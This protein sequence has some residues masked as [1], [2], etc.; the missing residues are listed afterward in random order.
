MQKLAE[1]CARRPVFATM[2]A[3]AM[4]VI[5]LISYTHL[6]VDLYPR[7]DI[8]SVVVTTLNPGAGPTEIESQITSQIEAAV[9]TVNGVTQISSTSMEG[10]STVAILFDL[11]KNG[12]VAAQE[13]RDRVDNITGLPSTAMTPRV[14]KLDPDAL[15]IMR[16]VVSSPRPLAETSRIAEAMVQKRLEKVP[17]V[18][19]VLL[20]G[21]LDREIQVAVDPERLRALGITVPELAAGIRQQSVNLPGGRINEGTRELTVRTVGLLQRVADLPSL[22]VS[23]RGHRP[24]LLSELADV[25]DGS[26]ENSGISRWNGAPA[27]SLLIIKQSGQ[28]TIQVTHGIETDLTD[29][30]KALPPDFR[31]EVVSDQSVFIH[32]AI[33]SIKEHLIFG[34]LF[35]C[36]VVFL[37]LRNFHATLIAAVAIP[38]SLIATFALIDAVGFTLNQIT[39]LALALMVGIVIDDAIVVLENVYHVM[40]QGHLAPLEATIVGTQQIGLAVMAATFSLLAV[41]LPVGFMGGIVGRFL[42]SFGLT[43]AFAVFV[44]MIVSFTLTPAMCAHFLRPGALKK[45]GEAGRVYSRVEAS[46]LRLLAWS[47]RRRGVVALLCLGLVIAT[48]PLGMLVGKDFRPSE[49]LSQF[50]VSINTAQG[51]SL[52]QTLLLGERIAKDLRQQEGIADTLT[53]IGGPDGAPVNS[54]TIYVRMQ[55]LGKRRISQAE[56]MSNARRTLTAYPAL[57]NP[58]VQASQGTGAGAT[59]ADVEYVITGPDLDQIDQYANELAARAKKIPLATDV[60]SSVAQPKPELSIDVDEGRAA[61]LGVNASDIAQSVNAL[62]A[63][64]EVATLNIDGDQTPVRIQVQESYRSSP[65]GLRMLIVPST[66]SGWVGLRSV[67]NIKEST[68]PAVIQRL[69][70]QRQ[71]TVTANVLPGGSQAQVSAGFQKALTQMKLAPGYSAELGGTSK[72]LESAATDFGIAFLL[73]FVFMYMVLASQFESFSQPIIILMTLPLS[74]PCGLLGLLITGQNLNIFSGLGILLLFGV[75][76]KNAILQM[77]HTNDLRRGG[78][79][80]DEAVFQSNKD[81]LRPI[82]MTT[83]ALVAGMIPLIL[84]T[85]PGSSTSRSM[86]VL[87]AAGQTFCLVLTLIMVPVFYTLFDDFSGSAFWARLRGPFRRFVGVSKLGLLLVA[88]ASP[89]LSLNR[90]HG[91]NVPA[92]PV[93]ESMPGIQ[94]DEPLELTLQQALELALQNNADLQVSKLNLET[95]KFNLKSAR[96]AYD[97]NF[98]LDAYRQ[99]QDQAVTSALGGGSNGSLHQGQYTATPRL[100]GLLPWLGSSYST[101][102]YSSRQTTDS[103][104]ASLSPEYDTSLNFGFTQP[105]LRGRAI[106]NARQQIIVG[107]GNVSISQSQLRQQVLDTVT[108]VVNAYWDLYSAQAN[109]YTQRTGYT[110]SQKIVGSSRRRADAGL[111]AQIDVVESETQE[112]SLRDAELQAMDSFNRAEN[113]LKLLVLANPSA[114]QWSRKIQAVSEPPETVPQVNFESAVE[115]AHKNRPELEQLSKSIDINRSAIKLARNQV[116]PQADLVGSY[117]MAGVAGAVLPQSSNPLLAQLGLGASVPPLF[118]GNYAKSLDTLASNKFPTWQV[119][120][121]VSVP[122]GN[123]TAEAALGNAK[124]DQKRLATN[125]GQL[126]ESVDS[127]VRNAVYSLQLA[128]SRLAS[129]RA[130]S[131]LAQ[132]QYA[133]EVR[134]FDAGLSSVFLV[135]QR[136]SSLLNAQLHYTQTLADVAKSVAAY[137]RA[138]GD[139]LDQQDVHLNVSKLP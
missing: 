8:P 26:Q 115:H 13:V 136:Q 85:G 77:A 88:A 35:A 25:R 73:A 95:S 52:A 44:S 6:G 111:Q 124:V 132:E 36:I 12:D 58:S 53:T 133:S 137:Y 122:I 138:I 102:L 91:Q 59:S 106:D 113:A 121:R 104:F 75:V 70:R 112:S 118:I 37:F 109:L 19:Q 10:V 11:A 87:V 62:V 41:F 54:G 39:M 49:D 131:T 83:L 103:T 99:Q 89:L 134:K 78:M 82:L 92:T 67:A 47:M 46:Y 108:Q 64:Q 43:S 114:P 63:G 69:N 139:L 127:D 81:R 21:G 14:E 2:L 72:Q 125:M 105:L 74:V 123:R 51:T 48:V 18:G 40:D 79:P 130:A 38:V 7:I 119:E 27:L 31:L 9:N 117:T 61:D 98:S 34:S 100:T 1:I 94:T 129:S 33:D 23:Q 110:D 80:R 16:L 17:G 71:V 93:P 42:S 60:A 28:N 86:G 24:V 50:D 3:L 107:L 96:G 55:P 90:L 68:G 57:V 97:P 30:R 32:A 45:A 126:Q 84:A 15:P 56:A 5:G 20:N 22:A 66:K 128:T 65:D 116:L 120:L 135:N 4:V 101:S 76:K 29:I